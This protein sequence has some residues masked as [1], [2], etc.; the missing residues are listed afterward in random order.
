MLRN[1][2]SIAMEDWLHALNASNGTRA[3][4]RNITSA[5]FRHAIRYGFLPRH[6]DSNPMKYVR[7]SAESDLIPTILTKEQVWKIIACLRDPARTM[8]FLD[9]FTGLRISE[10]LGLKWSDIDFER[11]EMN[12]R[13]AVVY[14]IV[15][16]CK[17]KAS[18]KPVALAPV[19][20]ETLRNWRLDTP[21]NK[22]DDWVFASTKL[23]GTKPLTPGMLRKWHLKP[24]AKEAGVPGKIGWHTFRRT[25]AC[26]LP[27]A[28]TSRPSKSRFDIQPARSRWIY[29]RKRLPPTNWLRNG[30][31]STRLFR[32][33]SNP[34][35]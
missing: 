3:K 31:S 33:R 30:N 23:N 11:S 24:A 5:A 29:M 20:A 8:A 12:V 26:L 2:Q 4:I 35:S 22:P 27:T 10:L 34:P 9:A 32:R 19:L 17:S 16:H 28:W 1:I 15:G 7:Q 25:L 13:R 18:K 6:E 21:Y 14:G